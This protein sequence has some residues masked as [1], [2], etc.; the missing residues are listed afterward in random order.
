MK[1]S[2]IF[3]VTILLGM[4]LGLL[5]LQGCKG[6]SSNGQ[7]EQEEQKEKTIILPPLVEPTLQSTGETDNKKDKELD[8]EKNKEEK[9]EENK[10]SNNKVNK[11]TGEKMNRHAIIETNLGIIDIELFEKRAPITTGNF[12]K[13]AQK[14]FYDGVIFHRVIPSFMIQGGDPDGRGTG[15]PGYAI[16]DEFH[17]ELRHNKPGILSMANAG[18]NTGGS[19]F[20]ITVAA[21]P[22]LDNKHAVFGVVSKGMDVVEKIVNTDRDGN[23]KPLKDVIMEK[24]SI[25]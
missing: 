24:V 11:D 22:F 13:L 21:T 6:G 1:K 25:Q 12:I 23:D 5:L 9:K 19:Q 2:N 17:P 15:G 20:F 16:Q 14:G 4:L 18:P 3:F 7:E 8:K 10:D